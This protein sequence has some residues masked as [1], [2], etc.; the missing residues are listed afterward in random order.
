[1]TNHTADSQGFVYPACNS[2]EKTYA[3]RKG[4]YI[5]PEDNI[6]DLAGYISEEIRRQWQEG[7]TSFLV[8]ID[9]EI[10]GLDIKAVCNSLDLPAGILWQFVFPGKP[11]TN[12]FY[13]KSKPGQAGA[14]AG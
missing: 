8:M 12:S 7:K 3:R 14:G 11:E 2:T 13:I 6:P 1:M 10:P 4:I 9:Q 5:A